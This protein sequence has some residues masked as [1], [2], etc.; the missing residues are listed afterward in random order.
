[1]NLKRHLFHIVEPSPWPLMC[2][3]GAFF[4]VSGLVFY[5]QEHGV[6]FLFLGFFVLLLSAFCWFNDIIN[7]ATFLGYHTL[8]VR[9]GLKWGFLLFIASEIMLFLGF[10][11]AFFHSSLCVAVELGSIW[12]PIGINIIPVFD[13]PF[14]NTIL[15][16][17]SG[18]AVTWVHRGIALGSFKECIDGFS[19]TIILGFF[20]IFLQGMEYYEACFNFND[21]IMLVLFIC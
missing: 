11:W 18:F 17:V 5:M 1:M 3:F 4:F 14:F 7:E 10:F 8:V 16:I 9:K 15:L 6:K 2:S 20:F 13:Y 19:I 12:P 21:S